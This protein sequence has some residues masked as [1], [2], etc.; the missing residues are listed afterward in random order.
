MSAMSAYAGTG[1]HPT[2]RELRSALLCRP[3]L[4]LETRTAALVRGSG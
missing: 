3:P 1:P 4:F 2:P